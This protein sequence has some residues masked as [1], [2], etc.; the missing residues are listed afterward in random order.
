MKLGWQILITPFLAACLLS[1]AHPHQLEGFS[2][3]RQ[4]TVLFSQSLGY[5]LLPFA[6]GITA[7][8]LREFRTKKAGLTYLW[9]SSLVMVIPW[10]VS[11]LHVQQ[12]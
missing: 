4:A 9:V 10:A 6:V 12:S 1:L 5:S 8:L 7:H 2:I 3:G 11:H